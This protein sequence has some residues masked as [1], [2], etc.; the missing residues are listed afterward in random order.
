MRHRYQRAIRRDG[1]KYLKV[2][3]N[4]YLFDIEYDPRERGDLSKKTAGSARRTT[5]TVGGLGSR[6][7][8]AA[9]QRGGANVESVRDALV[10]PNDRMP[11][12]AEAA[13]ISGF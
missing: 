2:A 9:D 3:D 8:A 7:V 10:G 1:W 12:L 5:Q 11:R 6:Y 13:A 4:E